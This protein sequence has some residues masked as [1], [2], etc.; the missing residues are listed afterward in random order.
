MASVEV[1]KQKLNETPFFFGDPGR[2]LFGLLHEPTE[3]PA[4]GAFVFC[5]PFAEEKLWAHRVYVAFA[6]ALAERGVAVLRFDHFGHG[7]SDGRFEEATLE[8]W[9]QDIDLALATVRERVPA[10][11]AVGIL[12]LRLGAA[13]AAMAA[14]SHPEVTQLVLWDPVTQ[15]QKYAQEVLLSN[16]AT[17]MATHGKV[18]AERSVLETQMERGETVNVDG[19]E[20]SGALFRQLSAIDLLSGPKR[21]VGKCFVAQIDRGPKP[22]RAD[23]KTLQAGYAHADIAQV[24]EQP[25]WKE[26]K[27]YYGRAPRLY[28]ATLAWLAGSA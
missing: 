13:L 19:Y 24:V 4:V 2:Q 20:M 17:Q 9:D 12:G 11:R 28:D 18:V 22:L 3:R 15:G 5:H 8:L 23:V 25:F 21:F 7:D 26:I 6:R 14:E 10:A 1:A 16:L 27:E